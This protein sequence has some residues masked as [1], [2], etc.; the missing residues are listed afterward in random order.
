M[1]KYG[2]DS[3]AEASLAIDDF[4]SNKRY[5]LDGEVTRKLRLPPNIYSFSL[6]WT[7]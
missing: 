7:A 1:T 5:K 2:F 4:V 3:K 6:K